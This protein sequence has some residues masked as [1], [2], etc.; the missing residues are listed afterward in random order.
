MLHSKLKERAGK[1]LFAV[2]A[3]ICILAVV[4][5]FLFIII[6]SIPALSKIGVF[7]FIFGTTWKP[8]TSDTYVEALTGQYGILTM[9]VGTIFSTVGALAV[10]GSLG[11]FTAVYLAF[12]CKGKLKQIFNFVINLL[13]GIPSVIYGFF[14]MRVVSKL[15]YSLSPTG[16]G[17]GLL[18]VSVVLGMMILPT[19]VALTKTSLEAVPN[20]Y[21]EGARALGATHEKAVFRTMVPAARSGIT[22]AMILGIG[23]ALGET[24]AVVMLAG[25]SPVFPTGF[26]QSFRTLTANIVLEMGYAGEVQMGA[27][28]ATGGVLLV[29]VAI[30]NLLLGL[31]TNQKL[32]EKRKEKAKKSRDL[33]GVLH[34]KINFAKVGKYAS[35]VATAFAGV[36]LV[37]LVLF[38]LINGLPHITW[39][40]LFGEF[41]F[42]G[43]VT[44][45]PAIVSTLMVVFI[46]LIVAIP[47]GI[48]TAIFL[49]EYTKKGSKLVATIRSAIDILSGVPSIV[50][51][52]FGAITFVVLTNNQMT[53]LAGGLTISLMLLPTVVR[54]TEESLK[55]VPDSF[56]EGS[57]ALGAGKLRT[58]FRVVLPS[59]FPG[60]MSAVILSIGRVVSE[61]APFM[62]TMGA[63][64]K[65]MPDGFLSGGTSLAV[66]L[67]VLAGEGLHLNEAYATAAVLLILVTGINLLAQYVGGKLKRDGKKKKVKKAKKA[68]L[69]QGQEQNV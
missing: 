32:K 25:N 14:G 38:V 48:A 34:Q 58:I 1:V 61:S 23:R 2:T 49:N 12:F 24:M 60:I 40:L 42:G 44:I 53:I 27:L 18:L 54:S 3:C 28:F 10:G 37:T 56:R 59:A 16:S 29:F 5:I 43:E 46:S 4:A 41:E 50:Y 57:L 52:L 62:F 19:V 33:F 6:K 55:A 65:P 30:I 69:T 51:G 36:F 64:L 45:F 47:L 66:A 11:Y 68:N 31:V 63:S 21:Y 67:Y 35:F 17:S 15:F 22:A 26:F 13:A 7:K 39:Q 9:I 8:D 20:P